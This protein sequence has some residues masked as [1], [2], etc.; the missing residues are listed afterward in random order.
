MNYYWQANKGID[1]KYLFSKNSDP[2]NKSAVETKQTMS[3]DKK[4]TTYDK[5]DDII[6]K[7][8]PPELQSYNYEPWKIR[9]AKITEDDKK[10]LIEYMKDRKNQEYFFSKIPEILG[11]YHLLILM[12]ENY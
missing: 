12:L 7:L 2:N 9:T 4:K 3:A 11:L 6:K 1:D 8:F 10:K 5:I